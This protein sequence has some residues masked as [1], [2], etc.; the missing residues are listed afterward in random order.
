MEDVLV[1]VT[2]RSEMA[3][4]DRAAVLADP[5]ALAGDSGQVLKRR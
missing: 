1:D 5:D 3:G 2:L 4:R